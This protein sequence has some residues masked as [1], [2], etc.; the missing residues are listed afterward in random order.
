MK[1]LRPFIDI[2]FGFLAW[3]Y[4]SSGSHKKIPSSL[5]CKASFAV[6]LPAM[7]RFI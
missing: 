2:A 4:A 7:N 3:I 1:M 5:P 6:S